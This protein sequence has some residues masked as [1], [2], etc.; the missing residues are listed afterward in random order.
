LILPT[1][2]SGTNCIVGNY[3]SS[4][5]TFNTSIQVNPAPSP[6]IL[7]PNGGFVGIGTYGPATQLHVVGTAAKLLTTTWNISSDERI[8]TNIVNASVEKCAEI[9][10]NIPIHSFKWNTDILSTSMYDRK[11]LGFIAQEVQE[12][13]PT[14]I[15]TID[16]YGFS[17]FLTL[18]TDQIFKANI[19]ATQYIMQKSVSIDSTLQGILTIQSNIESFF[20]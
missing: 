6:I 19:G 12:V 17:N 3:I 10:A 16:A 2:A 18:D 11:V 4:G 7:Q 20:V 1:L 5:I 14:S 13:L 9:I 8:K 15:K